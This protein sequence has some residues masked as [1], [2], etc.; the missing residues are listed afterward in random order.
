[1]RSSSVYGFSGFDFRG[2]AVEMT[3]DMASSNAS[4]ERDLVS[5]SVLSFLALGAGFDDNGAGGC[6]SGVVGN[7]YL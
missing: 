4:T 1:M 2:F 5:C 3:S 6:L 7:E